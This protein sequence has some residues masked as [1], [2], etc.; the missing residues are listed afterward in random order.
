[1]SEIYVKEIEK[2]FYAFARPHKAS[3]RCSAH[4]YQ[5]GDLLVQIVQKQQP[6]KILEI[7][8][9]LG[10][11]TLLLALASPGA[12]IHTIE[13]YSEHLHLAMEFLKQFQLNER[14]VPVLGIAEE[15]L[16]NLQDPFDCI[17]FDGYGI[18]Y[19]F[20][21]NY[22]RLLHK[23]GILIVA[24]NHLQSKTSERFFTELHNKAEWEIIQQFG[25]TTVAQK[26]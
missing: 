21:P 26:I 11:S 24:N 22:H 4:A 12:N 9:G 23:G 8:T 14:I 25:D 16:P 3:H 7:G 5:L 20:L 18:H 17:F 1:M 2:L 10:Y 15:I 6:K 19:E 13:R